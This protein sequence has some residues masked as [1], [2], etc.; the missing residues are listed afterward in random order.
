M[1][2]SILILTLNEEATLPDCLKS[3]S[4][5]DDVVV[6]DSHSSDGTERIAKEFGA[7]MFKRK[8]D[9]FAGQR[10][11]GMDNIPFKHP[12]VLHLDADERMTPELIAECENKVTENIHDG[13]YVASKLIFQG[14]WLK[15]SGSYPAYQMRFARCGAMRFIQ[16]GHGQRESS[17]ERVGY[18]KNPMLH[19]AFAKG[20]EEWWARH[21]RYATDEAKEAIRARQSEPLKFG[22]L[23]SSDPVQ[24]R[25]ALK[26][27]SVSLPFRPAIKFLYL[28]LWRRG[29]LDGWAGLRYCRMLAEY[30]RMI[31]SK[32]REL[33]IR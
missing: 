15:H 7:R 12:W 2:F 22:S 14:Q 31:V 27:L 11:W 28:Y 23:F 8:F 29:W 9:D 32:T 18:L 21:E 19:H 13:Y 20:M 4:R 16:H 3:C 5:C 6:L 1:S 10:N 30:E 25:R 26:R 24:R 33:E 17:S